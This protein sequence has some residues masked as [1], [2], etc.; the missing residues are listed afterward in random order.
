MPSLTQA[1]YVHD[2]RFAPD[3]ALLNRYLSHWCTWE[4]YRD[5]YQKQLQEKNLP[6]AFQDSYGKYHCICTLGTATKKRRSHSEALAEILTVD[7]K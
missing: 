7:K 5:A 4:E 1:Q 3:E 6:A 2:L